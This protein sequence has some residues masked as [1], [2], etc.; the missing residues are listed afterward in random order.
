[1]SNRVCL[2]CAVTTHGRPNKMF[3]SERCRGRHRTRRWRTNLTAEQ[4][5]KIAQRAAPY[6]SHHYRENRERYRASSMASRIRHRERIRQRNRSRADALRR[7]VVLRYG[8]HCACCGEAEPKF[9]AL[10]HV[11][12]GGRQHRA[13]FGNVRAYYRSILVAGCPP[14][15]QLLCHNCNLAKGFFG[16]CPHRSNLGQ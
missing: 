5:A 15:I 11:N 8:G 4:K 13:R 9:L 14:A 7:E 10:D 3:C 16:A 2:E 12:G 6:K 1:M